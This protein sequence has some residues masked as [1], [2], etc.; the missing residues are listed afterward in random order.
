M[1]DLDNIRI[2]GKSGVDQAGEA[3]ELDKVEWE[4]G[5]FEHRHIGISRE[6]EQKMLQ[7]MGYDS[8]EE[9]IDKAIPPLF[10]TTIL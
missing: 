7:Q 3:I 8:L 5:K 9:L 4:E 6:D 10:A 1:L 2:G